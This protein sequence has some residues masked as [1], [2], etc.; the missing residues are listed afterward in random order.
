MRE[1]LIALLCW[2]LIF[3]G[4]FGLFPPQSSVTNSS[5]PRGAIILMQE[6]CPAGFTE[7]SALNGKMPLGTLVANGD[8]G[9]TGGSS[10][11]TPTGTNCHGSSKPAPQTSEE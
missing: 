2:L 11:I 9:T 3:R 7:L 4:P 6:A 5:L 8:V 1:S 10:S